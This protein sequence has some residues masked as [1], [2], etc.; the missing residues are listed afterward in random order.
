MCTRVISRLIGFSISAVSLLCPLLLFSCT[1]PTDS[2][3]NG[4]VERERIGVCGSITEDTVWE[5]GKDYVVVGDVVV[6]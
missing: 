1:Q 2:T 5:E 6:E 4:T 3:D